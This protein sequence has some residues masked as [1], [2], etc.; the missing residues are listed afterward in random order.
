M[1]LI[2]DGSVPTAIRLS[3]AMVLMQFA[4]GTLNDVVDA[5]RDADRVPAKPIAAGLIRAVTGRRIAVGSGLGGL[6]LAAL[7]G[8]STLV[9][10]ALGLGCG[11]VYDLALSR[12]PI[13]WLPLALALPLVPV[14]AWFGAVDGLPAN[15]LAIIPIAML[16]GAGLAVGN[17]L[18]DHTADEVRGRRTIAVALGRPRAWAAHA[19]ALIGV[20][21]LVVAYRPTGGGAAMSVSLTVGIALVL[22]GVSGL[23]NGTD[24]KRRLGWGLEAAGIATLGIG[25]VLASASRPQ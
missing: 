3:V 21:I 15:I 19:A 20:I 7:S 22:G 11:A 17:A 10:A 14:Y 4:I 8:P 18:V 9:I 12:T 2:A 16:A 24:F 5:P 1:A 25:W 13:S 23:R 6:A